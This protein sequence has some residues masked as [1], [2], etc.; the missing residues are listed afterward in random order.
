MRLPRKRIFK[1]L[2]FSLLSSGLFFVSDSLA[3]ARSGCC[4][5]HDGV[6]GCG[7]CDGTGL[8]DT[9]APYYPECSGG[10][11]TP[12]PVFTP[13]ATVKPTAVPT[14]KST[15]KPTSIPTP[16]PTPAVVRCS[17]V[18]D[19]ICPQ[20]CTAGNDTDCCG[21]KS[22]YSWF[23][24]Y[25]CYPATDATCSATQDNQCSAMCIAGNDFDCC[26]KLEGYTWYDNWGC[27]PE[28]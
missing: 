18:S 6:C 1:F 14:H 24:N 21:K 25:G 23:E 20:N 5:H 12:Q 16:R 17:A 3:S 22:G 9:C 15:P 26:S 27:Y 13:V 11:S 2:F 19:S 4:S 10:G 7:C 28:E 8:S